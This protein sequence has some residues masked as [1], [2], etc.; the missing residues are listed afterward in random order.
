MIKSLQSLRFI[1]AIMI[2][3][4]HFTVNG[5]GLFEAGGTCGV[6]FFIILSGVVMSLGYYEKCIS[7]SFSYKKFVLKRII[8]LYP[9]HLLCLIAFIILNPYVLSLSGIVR[10]TPNLLLI[11]SWIPLQDIYFSGNAVSWCL[12]DMMFFYLIFP[13][14]VR[15]INMSSNKKITFISMGIFQ[16]YISAILY[17]PESKAHRFL[18]ISPIF[19]LVDFII[20]IFI[21]NIYIK[22]GSIIRNRIKGLNVI[23]MGIF[24]IMFL[25]LIIAIFPKVHI[26][27]MYAF[28]YIAPIGLLILY[29]LIFENNKGGILSI[30]KNMILLKMGEVSFSFYMIHILMIQFLNKVINKLDIIIAWEIKLIIYF[31]IISLTSLVIYN[32][33]ELPISKYLQ[34][35]LLS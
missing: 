20:G 23:S 21:F 4:H 35:K 2:F 34:K 16:I 7:S 18:Y 12:S 22:W 33:F 10:L 26:N 24:T 27:Y 8:R 15:F 25:C 5:K 30:F 3:L 28:L 29:S 11:Q 19:R 17:M 1:F 14:L 6:S 13:F 31:I 9:L 32:I